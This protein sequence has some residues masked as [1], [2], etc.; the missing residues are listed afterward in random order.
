MYWAISSGP[1][2]YSKAGSIP[3][4]PAVKGM[5]AVAVATLIRRTFSAGISCVDVDLAN[6]LKP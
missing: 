2:R 4:S 1:M 5:H 3:M 6:N